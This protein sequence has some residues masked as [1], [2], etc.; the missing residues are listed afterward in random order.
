MTRQAKEERA[1][2]LLKKTRESQGLPLE[3]SSTLRYIP[4]DNLILID[5]REDRLGN[6]RVQ[7]HNNSGYEERCFVEQRWLMTISER[8]FRIA[9]N[10]YK[11]DTGL[12]GNPIYK[13]LTKDRPP[14][15]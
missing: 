7:E 1:Y 13:K 5:K 8:E 14:H 6:H 2:E 11:N 4:F 12:I 3:A 15:E 9:H 10:Y